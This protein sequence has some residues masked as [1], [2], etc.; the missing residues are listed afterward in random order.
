M[1]I[2]LAVMKCFTWALDS[3]SSPTSNRLTYTFSLWDSKL[4]NWC[5]FA[6]ITV[7]PSVTILVT[8]MLHSVF[9][10]FW[11]S[12][13]SPCRLF[14]DI[15][16]LMQRSI[17]ILHFTLQNFISVF[18]IELHFSLQNRTSFQS[19]E[20]HWLWELHSFKTVSLNLIIKPFRLCV[21]ADDDKPAAYRLRGIQIPEKYMQNYSVVSE[22]R[23]F[24][25]K[26]VM[27]TNFTKL[28][29][30]TVSWR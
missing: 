2:C 9:S 12:H 13:F 8:R 18:R 10:L 6:Y 19:S 7:V 4:G 11:K 20:L 1:Y 5:R 17:V 24:V 16:A 3:Q 25:W 22:R 29:A 14:W 23:P 26:L 21:G 28:H 15:L 30:W 27:W